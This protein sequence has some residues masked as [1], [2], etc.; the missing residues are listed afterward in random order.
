MGLLYKSCSILGDEINCSE[1]FWK[2]TLK[3]H[4]IRT[5]LSVSSWEFLETFQN[6]DFVFYENQ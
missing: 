2:D 4:K 3:I 6:N 5:L 1:H